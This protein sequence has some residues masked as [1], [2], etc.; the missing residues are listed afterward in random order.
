MGPGPGFLPGLKESLRILKGFLQGLL[1]DSYKIL[2]GVL[3]SLRILKGIFKNSQGIPLRTLKGFLQGLLA[4]PPSE[5][6]P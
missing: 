1:R 6:R 5:A 4:R 3:P 2:K